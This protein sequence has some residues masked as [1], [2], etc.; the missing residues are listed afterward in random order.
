[1]EA[2]LT[3][4]RVGLIVDDWPPPAWQ[5]RLLDDLARLADVKVFAAQ[6]SAEAPRL[7]RSLA[8]RV[9]ALRRKDCPREVRRMAGAQA[10]LGACHEADM[11]LVV[12]CTAEPVSGGL[13]FRRGVWTLRQRTGPAVGAPYAFLD[14]V[15]SRQP[16][17]AIDLV[18]DGAKVVRSASPL[19]ARGHYSAALNRLLAIAAALPAQALATREDAF[20]PWVARPSR[21]SHPATAL[22]YAAWL[23]ARDR[24]RAWTVSD[25]WMLGIINKP[26]QSVCSDDLKDGVRWI[27]PWGDRRYWADPFGVPG[28]PTRILCEEVVHE[29]P[30][31]ILKEL[32]L[33][34]G[35]VTAERR[36]DMA[37]SGHLS[38]PFLFE[39]EGI[40]YCVPESVAAGKVVIHQGD[41][42]RREWRPV[43]VALDG[44]GAVDSTLFVHGGLFW[45]AYSDLEFGSQDSLCLAWAERITGP[46]RQHPLNPVKIDVR[47]ARPG[48]TPFLRDGDLI[49][50]GQDCSCTYGGAV[51][52]N[53]I[54]ICTPEAFA[55]ETIGFIRPNP[56]SPNPHGLH[57]LSAWGDVTLVDAKREWMNPW[58]IRHKAR[59]RLGLAR[60]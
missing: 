25:A 60:G 30:T 21:P 36:L 4:C 46:W 52:L 27:G 24:W 40:T 59:K 3:S 51:A 17:P 26:I 12:D 35:R 10:A 39:S 50:P 9:P 42:A 37:V 7:W 34:G 57:T 56:D 20:P 53:R 58:V 49:R 41:A 6:G 1:M 13:S 18:C 47:S 8:A 19:I 15:A 2:P 14:D 22:G 44:V 43:C 29:E 45:L 16:Y 11:D 31:G 23:R 54:H 32:T 38:F 28:D 33:D 48:G 5:V 55:E